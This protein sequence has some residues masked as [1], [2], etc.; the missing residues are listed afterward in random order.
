MRVGLYLGRH[1]GTGGGIGIYARSLVQHLVELLSDPRYERYEL[2]LYGE[3]KVLDEEL[4]QELSLAEVL[5]TEARGSF[6]RS[7]TSYFRKLPNGARSRVLVRPLGES[8]GRH[9][10]S[11]VDQLLL[12]G[13][14]KL[15]DIELFHSLA[16][17]GLLLSRTP[18]VVTMHD[19]YQAWPVED[20]GKV[21]WVQ[22]LYRFVFRMQCKIVSFIVTDA[23]HVA[24]E[25]V[26]RFRFAKVRTRAVPLGIDRVF[27]E[28]IVGRSKASELV[29]DEESSQ[30]QPGYILAFASAD[31][32]K[33]LDRT[34]A[35]WAE[36]PPDLHE[37]PLVVVAPQARVRRKVLSFVKQQ[38]GARSVELLSW[39]PRK[40]LPELYADAGVV[41]VPTLAE[42]FGLPAV[43]A[44][45]LGVAVV[46]GEVEYLEGRRE[47]PGRVSL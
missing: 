9:A 22:R 27:K 7:A 28:F 29:S 10:S 46:C 47:A 1:A 44:Q 43:E 17:V 25:I 35:A 15:D 30:R 37:R 8:L 41:L 42:G 34:L 11:A 36:L 18:Q 13:L 19:L 3:S 20:V 2:V 23:Q 45:A 39:T 38:E 14:L 12:P 40:E 21:R 5:V 33:N 24:E 32:R 4:L 16:N 6:Y 26:R 31:P